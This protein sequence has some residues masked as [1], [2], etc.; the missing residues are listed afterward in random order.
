MSLPTIWVFGDQ[1]NRKIGALAT[2]TPN[3]HQILMIESSA[4]ISSRRWHVQRAHF[5][6]ASMRKF[7]YELRAA[8]F[9][10]DYR[11]AHSMSEGLRDHIAE[12][13]PDEVLV[14]EPNSY[15]SRM[16]VNKLNVRAVRSDQFLCHPSEYQAFLGSRKSIKME[17]FYRWQRKRLDVLMNGD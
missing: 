9:Q 6:V 15:A 10:V 2:A 11:H 16:L 1:L 14:T 3:T 13:R 4:K 5:I 12:F 8:G 17:D 7:A